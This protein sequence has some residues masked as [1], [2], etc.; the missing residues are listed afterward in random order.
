MPKVEEPAGSEP[1]LKREAVRVDEVHPFEEET[2]AAERWAPELVS[3]HAVRVHLTGSD[4]R[5]ET[6]ELDK[7]ARDRARFEAVIYDRVD[8]R[9]VRLRK[10]TERVMSPE[11]IRRNLCLIL[12]Q[13]ARICAPTGDRLASL[14]KEPS[15]SGNAR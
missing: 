13:C 15:H 4:L 12:C 11:V 10:N 1:L 8:C 3:H 6:F 5:V 2:S 7:D 9:D 14:N